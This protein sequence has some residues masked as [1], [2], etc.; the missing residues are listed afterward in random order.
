ML[1][2][3]DNLSPQG[4]VDPDGAPWCRFG[5]GTLLCLN[6][7]ACPNPNHVTDRDPWSDNVQIKR[8]R[9]GRYLIPDPETGQER[10]WTRVTTAAKTLE[11]TFN[12]QRWENRQVAYGIGLRDDLY[13]LAASADGP[14][15]RR[16][17]DDVVDQAKHAAASSRKANA[18]T[19]LHGIVNKINRG[20]KDVRIP[21]EHRDRIIRYRTVA[22]AHR[23]DFIAGMCERVVVIPELGLAGTMDAGVN[24]P[25]STLPVVSD[26]KTGSIDYAKVSIAQQLAAYAHATHWFDPVTETLH[27]QPEVN[28]SEALVLHLPAE[29][30]DEPR[31]FKVDIEEG[32]RLLQQSMDVRSVRSSKGKHLFTEITAEAEPAPSANREDALRDR[33][34][35]IIEHGGKAG[36]LARWTD[37]VPTLREGGL[38]PDQLDKVEQWCSEV[39]AEL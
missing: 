10:P 31:V 21:P 25:H 6:G 26:L 14:D 37:D 28:Q 13:A 36:L 19:A 4:L 16:V 32:W 11:D 12:L 18:G 23:L 15:D 30:D 8:D 24:W 27:E 7:P 20:D 22:A 39:E 2:A 3:G 29:G 33:V 5:P 9:F 34:K 35:H 1:E 17:L 38:S